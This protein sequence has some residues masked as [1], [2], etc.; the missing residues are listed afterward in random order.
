MSNPLL[1]MSSW[2]GEDIF[3][4]NSSQRRFLRHSRSSLSRLRRR[5][6]FRRQACALAIFHFMQQTREIPR[7]AAHVEQ[8]GRFT[9]RREP[10]AQGLEGRT[11]VAEACGGG[12]E[13]V[14]VFRDE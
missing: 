11:V 2:W 8:A 1:E 5:H 10:I 7:V 14:V 4:G 12:H 6:Q 13:G 3:F 9:L